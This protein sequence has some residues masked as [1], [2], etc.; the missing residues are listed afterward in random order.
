M[1][2][3]IAIVTPYYREPLEILRHAH[4]SVLAQSY[5][6]RHFLVA[7]GRPNPELGGWDADHCVLDR[8]HADFGNTPRYAGAQRAIEQGYDL[9]AFLDADNWLRE[10]HAEI[11]AELHRRTGADF[12]SC[13]RMLCRPDGSVMAECPLTD[14]DRFIDTSCMAFARG[15]FSLLPLWVEM[16]DYAQAICDR[17]VLHHVIASGASRAHSPER[18]LFYRCGKA[19]IYELLGEPVPPGVGRA[20][21]YRAAFERW[22]ADGHS[23]RP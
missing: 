15:G 11:L 14:P 12:L 1:T 16:P 7:D 22:A 23:P 20:P 10:D 21:D 3:R 9:I 19:G 8:N 2:P 13:G 5:P 18:T 4:D 6:C 17:W